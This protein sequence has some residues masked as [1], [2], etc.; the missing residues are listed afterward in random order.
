[1]APKPHHP[2]ESEGQCII[3]GLDTVSKIMSGTFN[4]ILR[5]SNGSGKT[6]KVTDGRFDFE[7]NACICR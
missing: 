3:T 7:M 1:M 4:L 2:S 5:E 6:I